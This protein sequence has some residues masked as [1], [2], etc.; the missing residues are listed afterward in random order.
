MMN[1]RIILLLSIGMSISNFIKWTF[2]VKVHV[3]MATLNGHMMQKNESPFNILFSRLRYSFL[4]SFSKNP[5]YSTFKGKE[6][7][8]FG[9][10]WIGVTLHVVKYKLI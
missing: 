8:I 6:V 4:L 7:K 10:Y 5:S 2:M 1:K 3:K 9:E